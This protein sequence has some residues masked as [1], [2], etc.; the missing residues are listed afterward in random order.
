MNP[1]PLIG[2]TEGIKGIWVIL[3]TKS[4]MHAKSLQSCPTLCNPMDSS[5]P[6]SSGILQARYWNKLPFPPPGDLPDPGV[7]SIF[8]LMFPALAGKFFTTRAT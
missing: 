2:F 8:L 4:C 6:G 1:H 5:L 7:Q 3:L